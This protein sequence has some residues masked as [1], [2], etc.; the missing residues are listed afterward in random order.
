MKVNI[1]VNINEPINFCSVVCVPS[2]GN[3]NPKSKTVHNGI[4]I[5]P[6]TA[7][8]IKLQNIKSCLLYLV[9]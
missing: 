3:K 4:I 5:N 1:R 7:E 2:Y 9:I 8:K 6:D